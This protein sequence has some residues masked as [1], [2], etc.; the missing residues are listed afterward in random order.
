MGIQ[1]ETVWKRCFQVQFGTKWEPLKRSEAVI[2]GSSGRFVGHCKWQARSYFD[3][4]FLRLECGGD[5]YIWE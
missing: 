2:L 4:C 1:W 3:E 5:R